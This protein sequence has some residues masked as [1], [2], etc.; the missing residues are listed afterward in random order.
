MSNIE[1]KE[2]ARISDPKVRPV[3]TS[4]NAPHPQTLAHVSMLTFQI[5][6]CTWQLWI[7]PSAATSCLR[8][9]EDGANNDFNHIVLLPNYKENEALP[10][11]VRWHLPSAC[12]DGGLSVLRTYAVR[13]PVLIHAKRINLISH[14]KQFEL[15]HGGSPHRQVRNSIRLSSTPIVVALMAA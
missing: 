4:L 1:T 12:L 7:Y 13:S 14:L 15:D 8:Q 6:Y 3:F 5:L 2:H 11:R 9:A 10:E